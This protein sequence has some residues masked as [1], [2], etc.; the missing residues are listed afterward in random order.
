MGYEYCSFPNSNQPHSLFRSISD[1]TSRRQMSI[2]GRARAS[3]SA[4]LKQTLLSAWWDDQ[5]I[6]HVYHL[7]LVDV[8]L[9]QVSYS[10]GHPLAIYITF[11]VCFHRVC[12]PPTRVIGFRKKAQPAESPINSKSYMTFPVIVVGFAERGSD[13]EFVEG[14]PR[15]LPVVLS[16][17]RGEVRGRGF[18]VE[19]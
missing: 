17:D 16:R 4:C 9:R 10:W 1:I 5:F 7:G 15:S 13:D 8:H 3:G 11:G 19:S 6:F 14:R 2:I 18:R 12:A